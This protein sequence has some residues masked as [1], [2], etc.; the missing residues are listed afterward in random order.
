MRQITRALLLAL[1]V[2]FVAA[3]CSPS[4]SDVQDDDSTTVEESV[5]DSAETTTDDSGEDEAAADATG[6]EDEAAA[7]DSADA[8]DSA[9]DD[10]EAAAD[11]S[12]GDGEAATADDSTD[13][14]EA[15]PNI[16]VEFSIAGADVSGTPEAICEQV[17]PVADAP[18]VSLSGPEDVL[19]EGVDYRAIFC[20]D[21]GPVY[22]DLLE[23]WAPETVN[24]FVYLS[25]IG[26]YNNTIFH[27]VLADFMA[28]GGDPEG[29]GTG[30]PGYRFEDEFVSFITFDRP[31]L[32]AMAN[33]GPNT[34]GSQFF[35]T[36][37]P[38]PHLN[39]RHS[40]F[41]D[42]LTGQE[43]VE[44]IQQRDPQSPEPADPTILETVVIITESDNIE[45]DIPD[46]VEVASASDF[47]EGFAGLEDPQILP[48]DLL[49][50]LNSPQELNTTST[51]RTA[52]SSVQNDFRS[53]LNDNGHRFRVTVGVNNTA[54]SADYFF[55]DL[56]YTLDAFESAEAA[57]TFIETGV[58]GEIALADGYEET[59]TDLTDAPVFIQAVEGCGEDSA[60]TAG[61]VHLQR[62]RYV[63]TVSGVFGDD[64]MSQAQ[65][66]ADIGA[67]LEQ[68]I[69]RLFE[70]LVVE[71][72]RSEIR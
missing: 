47:I 55:Q 5:G 24:N 70:P 54:C 59:V 45:A 68:N 34:N 56:T 15:V 2:L 20:T 51:V 29:T 27:R 42:V 50:G 11:D 49:E 23:T 13:E 10:S 62:G 35:I 22:I 4:G 69:T 58:L 33:A 52:P 28:Q 30:G 12:D 64:I 37:V 46:E 32:L 43:T 53:A 41:G 63:A 40:I 1:L 60:A 9:D 71:A 26:F 44:A 67:V 21:V 18:D 16:D 72:F 31:G 38:T 36:T 7:N 25:G 19:E 8:S 6:D 65:Q 61:R 39:F 57:T 17:M 66:A 3:A 48:E 14:V